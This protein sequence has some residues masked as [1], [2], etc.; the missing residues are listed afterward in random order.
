MI[1]RTRIEKLL[2]K[3]SAIFVKEHPASS[4]LHKDAEKNFIDGVPMNWMV[5]W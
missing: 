2:E 4:Y 3:E 5:K 1:D